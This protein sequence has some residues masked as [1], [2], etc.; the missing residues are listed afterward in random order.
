M[1]PIVE[2]CCELCG[3]RYDSPQKAIECEK[4]HFI[5]DAIIKCSDF[6]SNCHH[7]FPGTIKVKAGDRTVEYHYYGN[8]KTIGENYTLEKADGSFVLASNGK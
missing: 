6:K 2:Y 4:A 8:V 5:P 7:G 3:I 1:K